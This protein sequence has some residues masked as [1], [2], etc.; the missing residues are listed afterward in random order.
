MGLSPGDKRGPYEVLE[1]IG[2]GGM[3]EVYR[4]HDMRL[5]RLVALKQLNGRH[6]GG[7][8][9]EARAIAAL[10]HP[11]ICQIYDIGPDYLI[12]EHIEGA[13]IAGPA[14]E[15]EAVRLAIQITSALQEAHSRGVLHRDL[16]P[17]NILVTSSGSVKLIDFGLAKIRKTEETGVTQSVVGITMGTVAYMSPEQAEGIEADERSD[18][19]SLGTVFYELLSGR[20]PFNGPSAASV[21]TAILRDDPPPLPVSAELRRIVSKCMAKMPGERYASMTE[22]RLDLERLVHRS[23]AF[24]TFAEAAPAALVPTQNNVGREAQLEQIRRACSRVR[25][26]R[27]LIVAVTGEAGIGKTS[28]IENFLTEMAAR[29]ER[30]VVAR[31]RCSQRLAG[32]EPYLPILEAMESLLHSRAGSLIT[33][34]MKSVAPTWYA[35]VARRSAE[36]ESESRAATTGSSQERMKREFG[37]LCQELSRTQPL[38][39][40]IDDLH[41]ADVS[42]VDILNYLA[43]RFAETRTL[44]L[45]SYRPS[46]MALANHPFLAIRNDLQARGLLQQVDLLFLELQDVVRYLDLEFPGHAFPADFAAVIH[47]K[48][49]GSPLF[50]ADLVRYLRD[51]GGLVEENGR[52]E[53]ARALPEAPRDLPA[54]VRGMI[55]RKI[56]QVD[57]Q[58]LR[59]LLAACVQGPEFDS[60][61]VAEA[62][63]IDA[64]DVEEQLDRLEKV[65][66]FVRRM[67]ESEFP[68]RSL[69]LNYQFVHVLYQNAL[70]D[71]LQPT[72]RATLSGRVARSLVAHYGDQVTNVAA[73]V[74]VLFEAARDFSSSAHYYY[75]AAGRSTEIFAFRE[76]LALTERGL[77]AVQA[78]PEGPARKQQELVLQMMK[79]IALRSTSGWATPQIEYAFSKARELVQGLDD[80]PELIPVLWATTLFLLIRGNLPECRARAGE[81]MVQAERSGEPPYLMAANHVSGVVREFIGEMA[82]SSRLLGR[83]RELHEPARCMEYIAMFGQDPGLI[84]RAMSS[85]PLWAL[86]YP[87]RALDRAQE[88]LAIARSQRLPTMTAFALVVIE[89]IHLYRGEAAESLRVGQEVTALCREYELPQEAEWSLSFQG[90]ALHLLD[91]TKDGIQ[92]LERSLAAQE[93]ISARL[94]R[95]AF[96]AMLGDALCH[97]DRIEDGLRA[98]EEGIAHAQRSSE[99]GYIAEL[100]RVR[101]ELFLR[102]GDEEKGEASLRE[103]I[104][105]AGEQQTKSFELRAATTLARLLAA[106]GRRD[107]ART[108]LGSVYSWFTEG[109]GTVDLIRA[110]ALLTEL[111]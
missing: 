69:T 101:G 35:L 82:E 67:G 102:A 11:H 49:E 10:N 46:D 93:A 27:G 3:G 37:S 54:S 52:W 81:L 19:F 74:A 108:M 22:L 8:W 78:L 95:T 51:T 57:E 23:A 62:S 109:H 68:D 111:G 15:D 106:T 89:G 2:A 34:T 50:M 44:V 43:G 48:T 83:A 107:E 80:P 63:G 17:G 30:A 103:A 56:E 40:F 6:S 7:F 75:L 55:Q 9:H 79:G 53:L 77:N 33:G 24:H 96:L 28:V 31:G 39:L 14:P 73:R 98:V 87:D 16:K 18:I 42:T 86:G 13:P 71:S 36:E 70:Y 92:V 90:Y 61:T 85:R 1:L 41:W 65:N 21:L 12:M 94:V 105:Y 64:A 72:R 97:A 5:E 20:R 76:A 60:T 110:K 45:V 4:A 66:V 25:D 32:D 59:L 38:L 47:A 84:A 99:G 29:G 88:A 58:N 100:Y 26:G 91:R 104:R